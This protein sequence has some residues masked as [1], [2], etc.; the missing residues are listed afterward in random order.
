ML[1]IKK[2]KKLTKFAYLYAI[3]IFLITCFGSIRLLFPDRGERFNV[4][5]ALGVSPR[6]YYE[7]KEHNVTMKNDGFIVK[8]DETIKF[9]EDKL[10]ILG[11]NERE[12]NEFIIYWLPKLES[13]K[14][15]YIRFETLEEIESYMPLEIT[16]KPN[17]IIRVV[18]DYKPLNEIIQIE[19][20]KLT[21]QK[22]IGYSVIEWGGSEI[23]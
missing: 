7:G 15:N 12:I 11:L 6:L 8:G 2:E 19:E 13:N 5:S 4:V 16:P 10:E 23:K 18:M 14:Y 9:L 3:I 21:P 1:F 22:R 17:T 20:Q